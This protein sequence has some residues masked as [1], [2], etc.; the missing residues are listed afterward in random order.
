M[1][2]LLANVGLN[3]ALVPSFGYL[4]ASWATVLTEIVLAIAGWVLTAR[5]IGRIPV[6]QLTWRALLAGLVMGAVIYPIRDLRG[7]AI[8]IPIL[9]GAVVYSVTALVLRAV[10]AD[11]IRFAWPPIR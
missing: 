10:T 1:W 11:E 8:A 2:S 9:A 3:F 7:V 4:A 5:Y 6:I